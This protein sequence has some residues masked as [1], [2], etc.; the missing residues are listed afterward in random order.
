M[1]LATLAKRYVYG[2]NIFYRRLI[3]NLTDFLRSSVRLLITIKGQLLSWSHFAKSH[4]IEHRMIFLSRNGAACEEGKDGMEDVGE[5]PSD[6]PMIEFI[7][8]IKIDNAHIYEKYYDRKRKDKRLF[9]NHILMLIFALSISNSI[10]HLRL[11]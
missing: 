10:V 6:S 8:A 3:K 5:K 2:Q 11:L 9:L 1:S 4:V 7:N